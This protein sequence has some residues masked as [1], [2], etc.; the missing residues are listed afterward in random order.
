MADGRKVGKIQVAWYTNLDLK[1]RHEEL[2]MTKRYTP[3][4]YPH[5]DNYDAIEVD[6]V[7]NIPYDYDGVMGVPITFVGKYNP[8]Q[9]KIIGHEHDLNG[10]GGN[11]SLSQFMVNNKGVYFRTVIRNK[12]P[13]PSKKA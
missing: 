5:Y 2:T 1:K 7:V 8:D 11:D 12:H 10:N 3:E 6:K 13:E 4:E 9:F